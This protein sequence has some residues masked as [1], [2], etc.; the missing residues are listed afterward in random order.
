MLK[1]FYTDLE[2]AKAAEEIAR[3][4]LSTLAPDYN[5][6][7][8]SYE[9]KCYY[10]GDIK[11]IA[12]NGQEFFIEVKD[13]SRIADTRNILCEEEVYYKDANYFGKGNMQSDYDIYC[14]VSKSENRLYI[15]DFNKLKTIYKKG[16]FKII[17]H[18][19]QN[20]H[21]YL[22]PLYI[23]DKYG[24]LMHKINY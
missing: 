9:T 8:V 24:A 5:F 21:C 19:Q 22:L 13:D 15:L 12:P 18:A 6:V 16:E 3:N 23:A 17:P 10:K 14:I 20:T 2:K 7:D 1:E 4:V 11:A